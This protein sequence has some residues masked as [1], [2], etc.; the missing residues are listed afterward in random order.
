MKLERTRVLAFGGPV[1]W[2]VLVL[3]VLNALVWLAGRLGGLPGQLP[4]T[5]ESRWPALAGFLNFLFWVALLYL[6]A[7]G[8]Q[9]LRRVGLWSLRSRLIIAYLFIAV[10]PV[11][12]LL[13]MAG[14]SAY[15]IYSQ[16]GAYL[17]YRDLQ[18]RVD[19]VAGTV[20]VVAALVST[21]PALISDAQRGRSPTSPAISDVL[22]EARPDLPGLRFDFGDGGEILRRRG[23]QRFAG[24]VQQ[25]G[26]LWIRAV[27]E[28]AVAPDS[29][30][31]KRRAPMGASRMVVSASVPI[32]LELVETLAPELGFIRLIVTRR[33]RPGDEAGVI[34][35]VGDRQFVSQRQIFTRRRTLASAANALDYEVKGVSKLD[36]LD[37]R[38]GQ[39]E[40]AFLPVFADFSARPSQLNRRLF[41]SLGE[42]GDLPFKVL[43]GI[44]VFFLIIEGAAL[45]TGIALTR[46]ITH[47]VSDLYEATQHVQAG[48]FSHRV[49]IQR[50]DQLGALGESFNAMTSSITRLIEEQRLR[51][52]LENE[53]AIAQQVQGQ[54]FPRSLPELPGAKLAAICRAARVV[55][56]DYYDCFRLG[57]HQLGLVVADIAGKG[58]SAAL[59][60][61]SL[62]AALRSQI[63]LDPGVAADTAEV[64][65]RLNR[66]LFKNTSEEKFA[67]LFYGVYDDSKRALSYTNAGH[68][69]PF[70]LSGEKVQKLE[71]GG[72]VVGLVEEIKYEAETIAIEPGSVLVVYSD[73]L[74]EPENAY[75]EQFGV[76]RLMDEVVHHRHSSPQRIAEALM[77]A[78]DEWSGGPE[79]ADDMTVIV[80]RMD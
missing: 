39:T 18:D 78:V 67:T 2:V 11:V 3:V 10:V 6:F 79:Q 17:L 70:C 23:G 8:V 50:K 35:R 68:F 72:L 12:L 19:K 69:A 27:V 40:D 41:T 15:L 58:I 62:H 66:H 36:A 5:L 37:L 14:L 46:T 76:R 74:I 63:V 45:I 28:Q 52:R 33:A 22:A 51:H 38:A 34:L 75:G 20:E 60:M 16:L 9:W 21:N 57:P 61:A 32:T 29:T 73:G 26:Q 31:L 49:W 47:A 80:A 1:D 48:D 64:V 54:L 55:S 7:R 59:L 77:S 43:I 65:S 13:A 56:G 25:D 24:I 44:G 4:E 53:L 30:A 71:A 42:L